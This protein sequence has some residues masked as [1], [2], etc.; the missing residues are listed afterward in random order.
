MARLFLRREHRRWRAR[1]SARRVLPAAR[2]RHGD[3]DVRR[4]RLEPARGRD[5]RHARGTDVVRARAGGRRPH[6]TCER[7]VGD[8]RRHRPFRH[9]RSRLRGAVD[10]DALAPVRRHDVYLLADP[11][12]VPVRAWHREQHRVQH[13]RPLQPSAACARL[14]PDAAVC[15]D[16]MDVVHADRVAAVLADQSVHQHELGEDLVHLS[17]RLRPRDVGDAA[18]RDFVGRQFPAR[19]C[20]CCPGTQGSRPARGRRLC[21]QHRR[22]DPRRGRG[23]SAADHLARFTE[24]AAGDDHRLGDFRAA[25]ARRRARRDGREERAHAAGRDAPARRRHGRRGAAR[26]DG[27]GSSGGSR[28][29]RPIRGLPR[30]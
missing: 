20:L 21:R 12:C 23:Q 3:H 2:V 19:T 17:A 8:L 24:I 22:G 5:R 1:L 18:R 7:R 9:D 6:R 26:A 15:G 30:R 16:G 10:A 25:R 14:V 28:R 13:R 4:R 27:P 11:G 29:L